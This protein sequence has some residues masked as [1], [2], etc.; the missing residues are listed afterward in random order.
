MTVYKFTEIDRTL[1]FIRPLLIEGKHSVSLRTVYEEFPREYH[2]AYFEVI[3]KE[4]ENK[5]QA[6]SP[7]DHKEPQGD[8]VVRTE[9]PL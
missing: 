5:E 4:I 3:V 7:S 8:W 9:G 2:I 6:Q 1:A